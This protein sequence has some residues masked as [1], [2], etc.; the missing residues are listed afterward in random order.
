MTSKAF[1]S[2][3]ARLRRISTQRTSPASTASAKASTSERV[4]GTTVTKKP[5]S[6]SMARRFFSVHSLQYAAGGIL[7]DMPPIELCRM[8]LERLGSAH[9]FANFVR[10]SLQVPSLEKGEQ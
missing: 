9:C 1:L 6:E 10:T 2:R 5:R 3:S 7:Q 4:L 8:E